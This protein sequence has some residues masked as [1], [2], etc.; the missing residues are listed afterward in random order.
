[1]ATPE[2]QHA[3][4]DPKARADRERQREYGQ[5]KSEILA[6]TA[7]ASRDVAREF[8]E[9]QEN[10][11]LQ[12]EWNRA[13]TLTF[14]DSL[15]N[16]AGIIE[17]LDKNGIANFRFYGESGTAMKTDV[18]KDMGV[19]N[20]QDSRK[21]TPGR[22]LTEYVDKKRGSLS[23]VEYM[24]RY[25]IKSSERDG[26]NYLANGEKIRERFMQRYQGNWLEKIEETFGYHAAILHP[27]PTDTK[28]HIQYWTI[29]QIQEDIETFETFMQA[30]LNIPEFKVR[31]LRTPAGGGFGYD[32]DLG[33]KYKWD[34]GTGNAAKLQ[35]AIEK[36]R[37]GATWD[38]WTTNTFD[39]QQRGMM[40]Y[41][42]VAKS[43]IRN[44]NQPPSKRF[45]PDGNLLLMHSNYYDEKN[46]GKID[47]MA[48]ELGEEY[49]RG[50]PEARNRYSVKKTATIETDG[51]FV[52]LRPEQSSEGRVIA[53]MPKDA[54]VFVRERVP[55][56]PA[57]LKITWGTDES[58]EGYIHESQLKIDERVL[59]PEIPEFAQIRSQMEAI[60]P[61]YRHQF[62]ATDRAFINTTVAAQSAKMDLSKDQYM[63]V[64]NRAEQ[65]AALVYYSTA[66]NKYYIVGNFGSKTSTGKQD[67][68]HR[69]W[70]TPLGLYDRLPIE[71]ERERQ[72]IPEWRTEGNGGGG[73]GPPGSRVFLIGK[74]DVKSPYG[75]PLNVAF[76]KT[77]RKSL[78][79]LG[80]VAA[81][82]GCV[83]AHDA[84]IDIL[85]NNALI[86]GD[87][88]R[89]VLVGDSGNTRYA[90][91]YG[92]LHKG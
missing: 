54:K 52:R 20:E 19:S 24:R 23:R 27:S 25:M 80:E 10:E 73:F 33:D 15:R 34:T 55:G 14:D 36:F 2:G 37:P 45:L 1:M 48:R 32:T 42:G 82:H 56:L 72:Q 90:G 77:S 63:V 53:K 88:G 87:Y 75:E 28:N 31:H 9:E 59:P 5:K 64:I 29:P 60:D 17:H 41:R 44:V 6:N 38:M 30:W 11:R 58:T 4:G 65:F 12:P 35:S 67:V 8:R 43:A 89:Y 79:L 39:A 26:T 69:T 83:R 70:A 86:D 85:D 92:Q 7:G 76:H 18:L 40:D 68:A 13:I 71:R 62:T 3:E 66:A 78:H 84:F 81:S 49:Q 74:V 61:I 50:L 47:R 22:W 21:I 16:S 46:V 91:D 51:A 57:W